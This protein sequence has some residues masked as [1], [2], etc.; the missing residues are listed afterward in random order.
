MVCFFFIQLSSTCNHPLPPLLPTSLR[1]MHRLD[2]MYPVIVKLDGEDACCTEPELT[3]P[4]PLQAATGGS[5]FIPEE[6]EQIQLGQTK[7]KAKAKP[8]PPPGPKRSKSSSGAT[9]SNEPPAPPRSKKPRLKSCL[10][11]G[12]P[13]PRQG[14]AA[15]TWP[16]A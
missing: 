11:Q 15:T 5:G 6:A 1:A 14:D 12:L 13:Q 16:A 8:K 10:R 4:D 9:S 7:G 2:A 3:Q